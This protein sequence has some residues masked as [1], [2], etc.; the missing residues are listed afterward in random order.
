MKI[1]NPKMS[2]LFDLL[3]KYIGKPDK[4]MKVTETNLK[5]LVQET[6]EVLAWIR[7]STLTP[8]L[9]TVF[10]TLL[11][12]MISDI[13]LRTRTKKSPETAA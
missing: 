6:D 2:V 4:E 11:Y 5:S 7:N 12:K 3:H 1:E 8:S 9:K 13:S 10:S